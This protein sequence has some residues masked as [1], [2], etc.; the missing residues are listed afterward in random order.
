MKSSPYLRASFHPLT[1]PTECWESVSVDFVFGFLADTHKNTG[2][3]VSV[4]GFSKML[5]QVD[6][7]KSINASSCSRVFIGTI[8]RLYGLPRELV[9]DMTRGSKLITGASCSKHSKRALR[10]PNLTTLIRMVRRN[11]PTVL[12]KRSPRVRPFIYELNRI[13]ANGGI[14]HQQFGI[15]VDGAYAVLCEWLTP[16]AS[17]QIIRV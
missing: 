7:P 17:T 4:D 2:I 11:A 15:R 5:H 6:V 9:S 1:V 12:S 13:L 8:F 3:L 10:F 16:S 14:S